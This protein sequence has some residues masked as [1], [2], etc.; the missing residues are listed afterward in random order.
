MM[1]LRSFSTG[2]SLRLPAIF[3]F[4][5]HNHMHALKDGASSWVSKAASNGIGGAAGWSPNGLAAA[6]A[7][8]RDPAKRGAPDA[9]IANQVSFDQF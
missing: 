6:A 3:I 7:V 4:I 2:P 9:A 1:S 5:Q 8:V